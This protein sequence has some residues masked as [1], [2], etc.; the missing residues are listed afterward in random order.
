VKSLETL[1]HILRF[2]DEEIPEVVRGL[3]LLLTEYLN[4]GDDL[5]RATVAFRPF[6]RMLHR[7]KGRPYYP[8]PI[9]WDTIAEE[10]ER[11]PLPVKP[12]DK[13]SLDA[14]THETMK[15]AAPRNQVHE[16]MRPSRNVRSTRDPLTSFQRLD[17]FNVCHHC[18]AVYSPKLDSCPNCHGAP[19]QPEKPV[20]HRKFGCDRSFL[21]T[22]GGLDGICCLSCPRFGVCDEPCKMAEIV[23]Q[24]LEEGIKSDRCLHMVM[25]N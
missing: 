8:E 7:R 23:K 10:L 2:D 17:G 3:A 4:S 24:A 12:L 6:Y 11:Y 14:H 22:Q 9:T 1:S 18:G 16:R 21:C 20:I 25:V 15:P 5:K 13:E 19:I